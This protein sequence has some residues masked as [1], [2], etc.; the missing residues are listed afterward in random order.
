V[1]RIHKQLSRFYNYHWRI[2]WEMAGSSR[3]TGQ[4]WSLNGKKEVA[5]NADFFEAIQADR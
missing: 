5:S 1:A 2:F 4:C 3:F